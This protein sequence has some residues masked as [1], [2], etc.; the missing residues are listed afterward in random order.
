LLSYLH[1]VTVGQTDDIIMKIA[2]HI[3]CMQQYDRLK[4]KDINM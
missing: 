3:A 2:D 1:F 4:I